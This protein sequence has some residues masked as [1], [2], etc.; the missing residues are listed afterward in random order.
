MKNREDTHN[1]N[2]IDGDIKNLIVIS[3]KS[4]E[5]DF[6]KYLMK[7]AERR[8]GQV[9]HIRC[10]PNLDV[11]NDGKSQGESKLIP[12]HP[13]LRALSSKFDGGKNT[14]I[15]TGMNGGK[16]SFARNLKKLF[17]HG[18]FIFDV[19]DDFRYGKR[20]LE[21]YHWFR[22]DIKWQLHCERTMVLSSDLLWRYP[23]AFH[24]D[25]A[26]HLEP[27]IHN[28]NE[29]MVYIGS[30]DDRTDMSMLDRILAEGIAI[31][32]YGGI[33]PRWKEGYDEINRIQIQY[34]HCR[35]FGTYEN[36]SLQ[37]ILE[38]YDIGLVPYHT[39]ST[40]T[41]YIN[42]DKIYHYLNSGLNVL[43][44]PIPQA[45]KMEAYLGLL[46]SRPLHIQIQELRVM[47]RAAKWKAEKY[48]W[49]FR[50][51]Q[52]ASQINRISSGR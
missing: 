43:A 22:H 2:H 52:L 41:R 7:A 47:N 1:I 8:K 45:K 42:P 35:Y 44:S 14:I 23:K 24:L 19:Y 37:E 50:W 40:L 21:A 32:V 15:L 33:H 6:R 4:Y 29:R 31:D 20:G 10:H 48:S 28:K 18:E 16:S 36:D 12:Q 51:Q 27:T 25:N 34:P 46:D 9:A 49:D 38:Q 39:N 13:S 30:I 3:N 5:S 17:P 26:S 11:F